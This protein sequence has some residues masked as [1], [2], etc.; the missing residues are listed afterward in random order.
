MARFIQQSGFDVSGW[1]QKQ[2]SEGP[3]IALTMS[4][5]MTSVEL[6]NVDEKCESLRRNVSWARSP[7]PIDRI[8][9][10]DHNCYMSCQTEV[11]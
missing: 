2:V 3:V 8:A 4:V 9:K 6:L 5:Y 10:K 11:N 7:F 1:Y